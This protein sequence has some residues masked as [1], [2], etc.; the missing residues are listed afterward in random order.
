PAS[1]K[2]REVVRNG[3]HRTPDLPRTRMPPFSEAAYPEAA[4]AFDHAVLSG[5]PPP[6]Y[7]DPPPRAEPESWDDSTVEARFRDGLAAFREPGLGD[8]SCAMCH[9]P[10]GLDLAVIGFSDADVLRHALRIVDAETGL[11]IRDLVHAQRRRFH[12]AEPCARNT[13]PFQVEVSRQLG[14]DDRTRDDEFFRIIREDL[15]LQIAAPQPARTYEEAVAGFEELDRLSLRALP[16]PVFPPAWSS[17]RF[18]GPTT[19]AEWL[20]IEPARPSDPDAFYAAFDAYAEAPSSIGIT[21]LR[22][23]AGSSG[24]IGGPPNEWN[25]TRNTRKKRS[26]VLWAQHFFRLELRGEPGWFDLPP[27]GDPELQIPLR[28]NAFYDV[29]EGIE[30]ECDSTCR[31][32]PPR[33]DD[34]LFGGPIPPDLEEGPP[35]FVFLGYH[36]DFQSFQPLWS[37]TRASLGHD[38]GAQFYTRF[39]E[40]FAIGVRVRFDTPLTLERLRQPSVGA[41]PNDSSRGAVLRFVV[42]GVRAV[43]LILRERLRNGVVLELGDTNVDEFLD[44]WQRRFDEAYPELANENAQLIGD[45]RAILGA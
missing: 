31:G 22:E 32:L 42:N 45:L 6:S 21:E 26:A 24:D 9:S 13:R 34:D 38:R 35:A 29:A 37:L 17:D 16:S 20:P 44:A 5:A 15:G 36:Y 19:L 25:L 39:L 1:P 23:L 8:Q 4:L 27:G 40:L 3:R 7:N 18:H 30:L 14:G 10:D 33:L 11:R 28:D 41:L 12:I 2:G 43:A